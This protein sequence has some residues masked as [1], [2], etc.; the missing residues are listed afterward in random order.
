MQ[1][2]GKVRVSTV[3]LELRCVHTGLILAKEEQ[4]SQVHNYSFLH[5]AREEGGEHGARGTRHKPPT[6]APMQAGGC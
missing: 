4:I 5:W 3:M 6:T 1:G 2:T